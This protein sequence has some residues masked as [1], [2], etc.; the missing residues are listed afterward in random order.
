MFQSPFDLL[1]EDTRQ[2]LQL[3]DELCATAVGTSSSNTLQLAALNEP[4]SSFTF[5]IPASL[6]PILTSVTPTDGAV[7][8]QSIATPRAP[9]LSH[10]VGNFQDCSGLNVNSVGMMSGGEIS[11]RSHFG[12]LTGGARTNTPSPCGSI[13]P[14][15]DNLDLLSNASAQELELLLNLLQQS[16]A[17]VQNN[18]VLGGSMPNTPPFTSN[19]L[20]NTSPLPTPTHFTSLSSP[21]T[22]NIAALTAQA[23]PRFNIAAEEPQAQEKFKTEVCRLWEK[24]GWCKFGEGCHFAHG[25]HELQTAVRHSKYKTKLCR[26]YSQTGACQYGQRCQFIHQVVMTSQPP[27]PAIPDIKQFPVDLKQEDLDRMLSVREMLSNLNL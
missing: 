3:N 27:M 1:G 9:A 13:P 24:D 11:P 4:I 6:P 25:A 12:G 18:N 22:P 16:Q 8:P 20:L 17:A 10:M 23:M 19:P 26:N 2:L 7:T 14:I 21:S 15:N 5:D